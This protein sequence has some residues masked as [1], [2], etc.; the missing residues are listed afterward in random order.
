M[1]GCGMRAF[2]RLVGLVIAISV[3]F[4]G[5]RARAAGASDE[6][7][8]GVADD[9]DEQN[10]VRR[11]TSASAFL[12]LSQSASFEGHRAYAAGFAGYDSARQTGSFEAS[13]EAR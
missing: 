9:T 7:R 1:W 3:L 2:W 4:S 6:Q 13:A 11:A 8:D 10:G 12:P 5:A